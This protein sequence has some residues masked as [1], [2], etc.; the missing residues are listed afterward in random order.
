[1]IWRGEIE[2]HHLKERIQKPLGLAEWQVEEEAE[3]QGSLDGDVAVLQL[4][5]ALADAGG[6]PC[7]DGLR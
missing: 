7:R 3:S 1:M 4:P 2:A 6:L 5:S